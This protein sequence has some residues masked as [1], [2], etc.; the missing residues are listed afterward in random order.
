VCSSSVGAVPKNAM[1]VQPTSSNTWYLVSDCT[2]SED[3]TYMAEPDHPDID[4]LNRRNDLPFWAF[5]TVEDA[6]ACAR[7]RDKYP[8][9][10]VP[11][12]PYF[13]FEKKKGKLYLR[14]HCIDQFDG[15]KE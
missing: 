7:N 4:S 12:G 1:S 3:N 11:T 9:H 15:K 10:C 2:C 8:S 13:I 6:I 14:E 5:K